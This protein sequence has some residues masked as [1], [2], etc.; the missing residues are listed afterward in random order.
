MGKPEPQIVVFTPAMR[1]LI[2]DAIESLIILLD[3]I[4]GDVDAEDDDPAEENGDAEP[5]LGA[6][7][8]VDQEKAWRSAENGWG[9]QDLELDEA[10]NEPSLG[11]PERGHYSQV[12][13][14]DGGMQDIESD[15]SDFESDADDEPNFQPPFI[16]AAQ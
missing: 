7:E 9:G 3:E 1:T 16:F 15:I 6:F 2:A 8:L 13:W 5:S 11:A 4:D 10:D 12:H 14:S